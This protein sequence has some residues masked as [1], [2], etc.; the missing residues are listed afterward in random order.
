MTEERA[1]YYANTLAFKLR[2]TFMSF[3]ALRTKST[4]CRCRRMTARSS[5]L[6]RR[7]LPAYLITGQRKRAPAG[8]QCVRVEMAEPAR[9]PRR[10]S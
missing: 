3:A 2:I 1:R 6:S 10:S 9:Q 8:A 5:R 4:R 7:L